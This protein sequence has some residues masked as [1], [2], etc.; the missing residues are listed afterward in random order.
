ME[1]P[2]ELD[3]SGNIKNK[4][5]GI[6]LKDEITKQFKSENFSFSMKYID[7]S[8][9]IRSAPANANDSKFCSLLAQNAV[10]AAMAGKT[11]FVVGNW[12]HQ[13]T[14]LPIPVAV[15]SRK[16]ID[17]EDEIWWNILEATGQPISM[18]NE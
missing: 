5:I 11:D 2:K 13:F 1:E 3:A 9:I 18:K 12:N 6:Y 10:H 16:K 17:T 8:Y 4:D 7:P 14:L 15:A